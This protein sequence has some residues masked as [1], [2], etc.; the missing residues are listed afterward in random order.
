MDMR[1]L[2]CVPMISAVVFDRLTRLLH[3]RLEGFMAT[4]AAAKKTTKKPAAK[5]TKTA[6]KKPAAKKG[7]K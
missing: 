7:K 5:K 4:K 1:P 6:A 2:S 3:S